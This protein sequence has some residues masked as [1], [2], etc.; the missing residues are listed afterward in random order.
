MAISDPKSGIGNVFSSR[1]FVFLFSFFFCILFILSFSMF[2]SKEYV[3]AEIIG[4]ILVGFDCLH[5][6]VR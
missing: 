1:Y 5:L 4:S 3:T 6:H 2:F